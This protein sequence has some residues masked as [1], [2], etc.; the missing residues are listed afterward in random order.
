MA[1]ED[2]FALMDAAAA[3]NLKKVSQL[4]VDGVA[5]PMA[6]HCKALRCAAD[7][8]Y[9]DCVAALIPYSDPLVETS[10]AIRCAV[11]NG[12]TGCVELLAQ[13]SDCKAQDSWVLTLAVNSGNPECLAALIPHTEPKAGSSCAFRIAAECQHE[14]MMNLLYP[15]SDPTEAIKTCIA[16]GET[17]AADFIRGYVAKHQNTMIHTEL[18]TQPDVHPRKARR[19]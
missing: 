3:G 8:G 2:D 10:D 17:E 7:N 19:M 11:S 12:H 14:E 13:H 9:E 18:G 5:D 4:L 6:L 1:W 16:Q 15:H